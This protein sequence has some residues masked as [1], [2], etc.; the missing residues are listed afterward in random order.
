MIEDEIFML[1]LLLIVVGA[2]VMVAGATLCVQPLFERKLPLQNRDSSGLGHVPESNVVRSE[3]VISRTKV[4]LTLV[5]AGTV[6]IVFGGFLVKDWNR[7]LDQQAKQFMP[8]FIQA[9]KNDRL[10][11]TL[12]IIDKHPA[13]VNDPGIKRVK[14]IIYKKMDSPEYN[15]SQLQSAVKGTFPPSFWRRESEQI[16]LVEV[17]VDET[18]K[19]TQAKALFGLRRLFKAAE[20]AARKCIFTPATRPPD[21]TAIEDVQIVGVEF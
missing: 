14:E 17:K 7:P 19:V 10:E 5:F 12:N 9:W 8:R 20:D 4:P 21:N 1:A 15:S 6:A 13:I 11:E 3:T 18:G 2:V 16:V